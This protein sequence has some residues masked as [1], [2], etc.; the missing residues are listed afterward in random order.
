[1]QELAACHGKLRELESTI[2][3][4]LAEAVDDIME[5]QRLIDDL[6]NV[7]MDILENTIYC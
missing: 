7:C 4:R 2:E 6:E 5:K 1:V 3:T